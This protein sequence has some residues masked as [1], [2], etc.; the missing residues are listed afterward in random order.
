MG[1]RVFRQYK[2]ST[3]PWMS[4]PQDHKEKSPHISLCGMGEE[5][6]LAPKD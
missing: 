5:G 3:E 4:L 1:S 2:H 6:D